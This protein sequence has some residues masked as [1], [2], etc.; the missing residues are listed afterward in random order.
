MSNLVLARNM[1]SQGTIPAY[2]YVK[3]GS[4]DGTVVAAAAATDNIIGVT[5]EL[6]VVAG[7]RVDVTLIGISYLVAGAASTRG[8]PLTSDAS[9]RGV[10]AATGNR[11]GAISLESAAA[12]GDQIRVLVQLGVF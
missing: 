3:P 5:G 12:A 2:T 4:A 1:L 7:E 11:V 9:G 6:P 8:A 10:A